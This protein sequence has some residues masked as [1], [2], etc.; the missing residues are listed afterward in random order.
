VYH[1]LERLVTSG[2]LG[3]RES[4]LHFGEGNDYRWL[5]LLLPWAWQFHRARRPGIT[6]STHLGF[7]QGQ[8]QRQQKCTPT[9][10]VTTSSVSNKKTWRGKQSKPPKTYGKFKYMKWL[11]LYSF[12]FTG[13]VFFLVERDQRFGNPC[14]QQATGPQVFAKARQPDPFFLFYP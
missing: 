3:P 5:A 7:R 4:S 2:S 9:L 8:R 6:M 10:T 14:I 12:E 13:S 1:A 11:I